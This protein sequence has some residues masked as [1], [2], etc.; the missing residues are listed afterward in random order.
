MLIPARHP[1]FDPLPMTLAALYIPVRSLLLRLWRWAATVSLYLLRGLNPVSHQ[2][3]V[4]PTRLPTDRGPGQ[5]GA[6][7]C[8]PVCL[9]FADQFARGGHAPRPTQRAGLGSHS[10]SHRWQIP[11]D[12]GR[13]AQTIR[14][15]KCLAERCRATQHDASQ[16][17]SKQRVAG[18]NPAGRTAGRA[19]PGAP[20]PRMSGVL[21]R[22]RRSSAPAAHPSRRP[23][24][25]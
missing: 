7:G 23:G 13:R 21:V 8:P 11:G 1:N 12:T 24:T 6:L 4:L 20:G 3:I 2:A 16:V 9:I 18:S 25:D 19:L 15:A 22:R 17:P 10:G 5:L 14:P